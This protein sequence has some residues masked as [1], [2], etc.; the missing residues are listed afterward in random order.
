[1]TAPE[2]P[3]LSPGNTDLASQEFTAELLAAIE[4]GLPIEDYLTA[5]SLG[6]SDQELTDAFQIGFPLVH[7]AR[8]RRA[9]ATADELKELYQRVHT[10]QS[11]G[12]DLPR[13][14][15]IY[16]TS[17]STGISHV[18]LL[19]TLTLDI[20][21]GAYI[22]ARQTGSTHTQV[23]EADLEVGLARYAMTRRQGATHAQTLELAAHGVSN[24]AFM[25][26]IHAGITYQELLAAKRAGIWSTAYIER[27]R[28]G[29]TDH[30]GAMAA[31]LTSSS[32]KVD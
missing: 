16:A 3:S 31:L 8:A 23:L 15:A 10:D 18:E 30:E 26:A 7:Y 22:L 29:V 2:F 11:A 21:P 32:A 17:R 20:D 1:M 28:N 13:M 5:R 12:W 24:V 9:G 25:T 27:R 6:V 14:T 4:Q 19:E